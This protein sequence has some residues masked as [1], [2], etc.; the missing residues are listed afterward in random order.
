MFLVQCTSKPSSRSISIWNLQKAGSLRG[1]SSTAR[2]LMPTTDLQRNIPA[3]AMPIF[4]SLTGKIVK[5]GKQDPRK[6]EKKKRRE[7]RKGEREK[8]E[9]LEADLIPMFFHLKRKGK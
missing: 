7:E 1:G 3:W 2:N 8:G 9:K 4:K 6:K 5:R